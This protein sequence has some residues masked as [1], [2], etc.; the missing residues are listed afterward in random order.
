MKK[1]KN[2]EDNKVKYGTVSLP[3]PLVDLIKQKIKGTGIP[4]V[5][6][7]VTYVLRQILSSTQSEELLDRV[8]EEDIKKRLK[9]LGYV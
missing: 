8:T 4:S 3:M 2:E 7:Y 5:S 6:A 9:A 1:E